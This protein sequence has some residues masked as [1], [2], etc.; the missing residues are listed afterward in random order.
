MSNRSRLPV[1]V[2]VGIVAILGGFGLGAILSRTPDRGS[3]SPSP[4]STATGTAASEAPTP[5]ETVASLEPSAAASP[6]AAP[7]A[8][9]PPPSATVTF[10]NLFLDA[11][12]NPDGADRVFTWQSVGPGT[13]TA[14]L[15]SVTPQGAMVMCLK[16]P[17]K[18]LGC[19][20]AGSGTLTAKTTKPKESFILT[21]RGSDIAQPIVNVTLKF[22]AKDPSV[23]FENARFDGTDYP[24]TNGIDATVTPVNEGKLGI[25]ANW[26]GHPFTYRINLS[27]VGQPG[28]DTY[29][30]DTGDV[31]T[32]QA[33]DVR[34]PGP[35]H[36]VLTNTEGGFGVTTMTVTLTWP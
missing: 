33:F 7:S 28:T 1:L 16:T 17:T 22:P 6:S 20:T 18:T 14:K 25:K 29:E 12:A 34:P 27:E 36:I 15:S 19:R 21:L 3:A 35:W 24:D 30:P 10:R 4:Q 11:S 13:I 26:G 5:G 9:P 2:L 31:G 32:D 8:T 23:T